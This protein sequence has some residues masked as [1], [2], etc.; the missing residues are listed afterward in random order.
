MIFIVKN[1]FENINEQN[2][3]ICF[4]NQKHRPRLRKNEKVW[5]NFRNHRDYFAPIRKI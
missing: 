2:Q 4:S 3:R 5:K 1:V